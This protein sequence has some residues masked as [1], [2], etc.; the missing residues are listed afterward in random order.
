MRAFKALALVV[1]MFVTTGAACEK[2]CPPRRPPHGGPISPVPEPTGFLLF[3][4]GLA[5]VIAYG[6]K[7]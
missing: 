1:L 6:R 4:L 5:G 3:G 7:R 2:P